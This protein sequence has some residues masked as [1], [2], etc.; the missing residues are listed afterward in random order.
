MTSNANKTNKN[1]NLASITENHQDIAQAPLDNFQK[2]FTT[3]INPKGYRNTTPI[4]NPRDRST[5]NLTTKEST[6]DAKK[7]N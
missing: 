7:I 2:T 3:K 4:I 5:K 1:N 6:K